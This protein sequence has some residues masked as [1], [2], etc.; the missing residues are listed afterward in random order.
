MN[1]VLIDLIDESDLGKDGEIGKVRR[2]IHSNSPERGG[3][4][5]HECR[6]AIA[7]ELKV[8]AATG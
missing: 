7:I 1:A 5:Y 6:D 4:S 2:L 3:R 8:I